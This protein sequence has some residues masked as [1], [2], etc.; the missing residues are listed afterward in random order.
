M[1]EVKTV[2][3]QLGNLLRVACVGRNGVARVVEPGAGAQRHF[4]QK[5]GE[6]FSSDSQILPWGGP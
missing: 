5:A 2:G 3:R 1:D 6:N 4:R